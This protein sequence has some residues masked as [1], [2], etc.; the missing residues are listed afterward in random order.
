MEIL[1]PPDT[2]CVRW[3][4]AIYRI[5]VRYTGLLATLA[6]KKQ[7]W[8]AVMSFSPFS[9][10]QHWGHKIT[11]FCEQPDKATLALNKEFINNFVF[12]QDPNCF[13]FS[14]PSREAVRHLCCQTYQSYNVQLKFD[15]EE[16]PSWEQWLEAVPILSIS[17]TRQIGL[18]LW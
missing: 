16:M 14:I 15:P 17:G 5:F 18:N 7:I 1:K 8:Y 2:G 13:Y 6:R 3:S 10:W 4:Y 11:Q 12:Y 9:D